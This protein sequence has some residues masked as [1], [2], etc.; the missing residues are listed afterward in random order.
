VD[1]VR[2]QCTGDQMRLN[3]RSTG[4]SFSRS[5]LPREIMWRT[6]LMERLFLRQIDTVRSSVNK[7]TMAV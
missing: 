3:S 4:K 7:G 2:G 1:G 5:L 6:R